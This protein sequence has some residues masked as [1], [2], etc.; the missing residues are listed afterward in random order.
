MRNLLL[1]IL[2]LLSINL[3]SQE[4]LKDT[5]TLQEVTINK[6]EPKVIT[7]KQ[8]KG[9]RK[10]GNGFFKTVP[11]QTFL[12]ENLPYGTIQNITL[13]FMWMLPET[14]IGKRIPDTKILETRYAL[15]LYEVK[16]NKM[17]NKLNNT[18]ITVTLPESR[19]T[20]PRLTVDLST[21]SLTADSFFIVLERVSQLPCNGCKMYIPM[22][23]DANT[24]TN[25]TGI[26]KA[27]S[28]L[29][30]HMG[31]LCE[32]KTLTREY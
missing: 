11:K 21:L 26:E 4:T 9:R 24:L 22:G 6:K 12:I 16:D 25:V 17:G 5:I 2:T 13:H 7:V 19:K 18:P 8:G 28:H 27:A 31:L 20:E 32:I 10:T 1:P 23:Y 29:T 30:Y 14:I 3:Y 15:T